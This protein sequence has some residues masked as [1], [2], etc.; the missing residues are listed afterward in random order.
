MKAAPL[1][2]INRLRAEIELDEE[3]RM[4][5]ENIVAS[6]RD[7]LVVVNARLGMSRTRLKRAKADFF[8]H[9]QTPPCCHESP[10]DKRA[11]GGG[12]GRARYRCRSQGDGVSKRTE[13]EAAFLDGLITRAEFEQQLLI[14]QQP[15]SLI[16]TVRAQA[17]P[18]AGRQYGPCFY[19]GGKADTLD[20]RMPRERGGSDRS[21]NLVP[22]CRNCNG[23]KG[24]L[25]V[26]EYRIFLMLERARPPTPFPGEENTISVDRDWLLCASAAPPRRDQRDPDWR[27]KRE[28]RRR[29][30]N[31]RA[32]ASRI[33]RIRPYLGMAGQAE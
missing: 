23:Q 24:T 6:A 7:A 12:D 17:A 20:H 32:R 11:Q 22:A 5:L 31:A 13:L 8:R 2:H 30:A 9:V 3:G 25:A 18:R 33:E 29:A 10:R 19:C 27:V 28:A 14:L 15:D 26:E 4:Q 16:E 21:E 1:D